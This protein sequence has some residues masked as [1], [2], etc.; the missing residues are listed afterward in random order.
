[1]KIFLRI[2]EAMETLDCPH[3][4]GT[5]LRITVTLKNSILWCR[6]N[7]SVEIYETAEFWQP[8]GLGESPILTPFT[9]FLYQS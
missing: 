2:N 3:N 5:I 9:V 1:M 8:V 4:V 7:E 6:R